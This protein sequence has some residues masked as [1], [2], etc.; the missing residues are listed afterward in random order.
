[1]IIEIVCIF[2]SCQHKNILDKFSDVKRDARDHSFIAMFPMC[3]IGSR[4]EDLS[5]LLMV[6]GY[7]AKKTMLRMTCEACK[8][9]FGNRELQQLNHE[10]DSDLL[11]YFESINRGGLTYPS[12]FLFNVIQCAYYVFNVC[13][14][15]YKKEFLKVVNQKQT[16]LGLFEKYI[17]S[18]D[19]F[20]DHLL[21]CD[22]CK[23]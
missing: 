2:W 10:I 20:S 18:I 16:L 14:S 1:M 19:Y 8:Q 22:V 5:A 7:I 15:K 9:K 11:M 4:Q 21:V 3:Y 12:N 23:V 6:A 13:I 17:S